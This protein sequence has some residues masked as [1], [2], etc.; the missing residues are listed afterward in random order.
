MK[1]KLA[2]ISLERLR[3]IAEQQF[4]I[5]IA[6]DGRWYHDGGEIRRIELVKLF[7]SILLRDDDGVYW[8][9]TPAE[10]GRIAVDDAPFIIREMSVEAGAG[11]A[12]QKISFQTSLD[13]IVPLDEAHPLQYIE[14]RDGL[15]AKLSRPVYYQLA[16]YAETGPD[17]RFGVWSHHQFFPLEA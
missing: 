11:M 8:L 16:E 14:V 2:K 10:K 1:S 12:P 7:A 4:D 15:L 17:G 13:D 5:R 3:L 9:A 6:S